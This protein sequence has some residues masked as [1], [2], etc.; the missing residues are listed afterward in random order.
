MT[1]G[2]WSPSHNI[3]YSLEEY[4]REHLEWLVL[5]KVQYQIVLGKPMIVLRIYTKAWD[6]HLYKRTRFPELTIF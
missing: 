2:E 5:T 6:E 3:N 4:M 1:E